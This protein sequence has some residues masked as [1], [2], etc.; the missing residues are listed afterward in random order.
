MNTSQAQEQLSF[1]HVIQCYRIKHPLPNVA[2]L[3][4]QVRPPCGSSFRRVASAVASCEIL[5]LTV[6]L[7]L[8]VELLFRF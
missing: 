1:I 4:A 2:G 8:L 6:Y 5:Q 7:D 3:D